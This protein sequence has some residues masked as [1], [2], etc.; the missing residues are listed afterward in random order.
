MKKQLKASQAEPVRRIQDFS[1]SCPKTRGKNF[2][3]M[4]VFLALDPTI[5]HA[6]GS[7]SGDQFLMLQSSTLQILLCQVPSMLAQLQS[8][9]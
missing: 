4:F 9:D 3:Q 7:P 2:A 6:F 5:A 1:C 8:A